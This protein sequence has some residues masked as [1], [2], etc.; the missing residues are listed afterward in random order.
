MAAAGLRP[1]VTRN[2]SFNYCQ[3]PSFEKVSQQQAELGLRLPTAGFCQSSSQSFK[4]NLSQIKESPDQLVPNDSTATTTIQ[5]QIPSSTSTPTSSPAATTTQ[6]I[7]LIC[8]IQFATSLMC[9]LNSINKQS[10]QNFKLRIGVHSGQ[11]IA[12]VV[13]AQRPF[14][15]IWGDCVN[16]S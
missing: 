13:G 12:G 11:V 1:A 9:A 3:T 7:N 16:V 6:R 10:F 2:N 4:T 14:Y 15:D 5:T 8:I